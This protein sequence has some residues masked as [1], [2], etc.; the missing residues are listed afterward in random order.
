MT[1]ANYVS[2]GANQH[3]FDEAAKEAR[4]KKIKELESSL[5]ANEGNDDLRWNPRYLIV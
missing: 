3:E 4:R 1:E 2:I 5:F